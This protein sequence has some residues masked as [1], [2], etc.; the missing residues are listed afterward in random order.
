MKAFSGTF[1]KKDG[2]ERKMNFV[3]LSDI[4]KTFPEFLD[5][6]ISTGA[7]KKVAEGMELVFDLDSD[8]FR[9]F[10]HNAA[11]GELMEREIPDD[12]FAA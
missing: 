1:I 11:I 4:A 12:I 9:Y 7:D 6:R 8:N 10:N 5:A 2:S 3:K